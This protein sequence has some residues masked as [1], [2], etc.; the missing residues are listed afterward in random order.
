MG[1]P[2]IDPGAALTSLPGT[3]FGKQILDGIRKSAV[4]NLRKGDVLQDVPD[5]GTG[6]H[7]NLAQVFR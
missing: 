4:R 7:P 6:G 5:C 3:W 1:G 2:T